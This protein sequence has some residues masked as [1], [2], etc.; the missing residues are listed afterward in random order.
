MCQTGFWHLLLRLLPLIAVEKLLII[1]D[2]ARDHVEMQ[3]LAAFGSR[4]MNSDRLSG[5]A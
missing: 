5:E 2:R 1:V 4:Y 3:R